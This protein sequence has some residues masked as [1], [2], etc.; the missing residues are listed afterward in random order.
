[1]LLHNELAAQRNHE[2]HAQPAADERQ[3]EDAGVLEIEAEK[4]QRRQREDDARSD[5]LAG[6][7]GGLDD[8][9]FEDGGA[10]EGAQNADGEHRD[11]DGG[12]DGEAGAQAH[13]DRDCAE[14]DAEEGAQQNGAEG[15]FAG[16]LAGRNKRLKGGLLAV[17][18]DCLQASG[19]SL[20]FPE[21]GS[22]TVE[23]M[24]RCDIRA[25]ALGE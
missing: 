14:D 4:D 11:G 1:M 16:L 21:G 20:E 17:S 8:V 5:G 3:H 18:H 10:A 9:V 15:E 6:V 19:V 7:A 22:V 25:S 23:G 13:V 24:Q 2:Q 12:G